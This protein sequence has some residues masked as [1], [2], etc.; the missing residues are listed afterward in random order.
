ML[1]EPSWSSLD[2]L[3][4]RDN[5]NL[6][7]EKTEIR[8]GPAEF[9]KTQLE[10]RAD[11]SSRSGGRGL[12]CPDEGGEMLLQCLSLWPET[13]AA[14]VWSSVLTYVSNVSPNTYT[15]TTHSGWRKG[16]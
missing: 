16:F 2:W 10:M 4:T 12:L 9:D 7:P 14:G 11:W 5:S 8:P 6:N 1:A 13:H 3:A 15:Y